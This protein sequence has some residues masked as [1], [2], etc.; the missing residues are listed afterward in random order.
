MEHKFK[1]GDRVRVIDH[2]PSDAYELPNWTEEMDKTL[3]RIGV[4][5]RRYGDILHVSFPD[6]CWHYKSSWLIPVKSDSNHDTPRPQF[7]PGNRVRVK[8]DADISLPYLNAMRHKDLTVE[9]YDKS[10]NTCK[11]GGW[12]WKAEWLEPVDPEPVRPARSLLES[13][14]H[15]L[16]SSVKAA[17]PI[18]GKLPLINST[19]LLTNIKLD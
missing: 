16:I 5:K 18:T 14:I 11:A 17:Q 13:C 19:R 1:V 3:G 6:N 4:V 2:R 7:K 12:W 9:L 8:P 15:S 10:D